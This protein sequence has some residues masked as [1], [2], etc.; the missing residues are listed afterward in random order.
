[1]WSA[2]ATVLV[3]LHRSDPSLP[4]DP[5]LYVAA[6]LGATSLCRPDPWGELV[7][8]S[9]AERYRDRIHHIIASL[10]KELRVE[11]RKVR[12]RV[13]DGANCREALAALG[14]Q[15]SPL[16]QYIAAYRAY[17]PDAAEVFREPA[18]RQHETCPLY[19][20]ACATL[21]PAG[22]YPV[23]GELTAMRVGAR[24]THNFSLN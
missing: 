15:L 13:A 22:A 21:L 4:I 1:M 5:E 14:R 8:P 16:S 11:L 9:A 20:Q 19:R 6:Q 12:R 18:R 10:R 23:F 7:H 2:A 17:G 3:A 24:A